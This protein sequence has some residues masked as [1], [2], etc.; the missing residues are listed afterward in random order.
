MEPKKDE[1]VVRLDDGLQ[2]RVAVS[3][4]MLSE[5]W[6]VKSVPTFLAFGPLAHR[7]APSKSS[8]GRPGERARIDS[9]LGRWWLVKG[10]VEAVF[11]D[12]VF[13]PVRRPDL[14]EGERVRLT[15]ESMAQGNPIDVLEL[16]AR[17]Y[18]GLSPKDIDEIEEM[19]RRQTFFA[20]A[21]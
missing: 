3:V 6:D 14:P 11:Q 1:I 21:H 5:G 19:A 2:E 7:Y 13:R 10:T 18:E 20:D 12:G 16:A 4:N 15:V 8:G 9:E 17:V